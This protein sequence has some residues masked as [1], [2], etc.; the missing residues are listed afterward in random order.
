MNTILVGLNREWLL[1]EQVAQLFQLA[2]EARVLFTQDRAEM[3][4]VLDT[5]QIAVAGVPRDLVV[6]APNLRWLQQWG[7]GADWLLRCPRAV[8]QDWVLTNVSGIHA[9][10]I[11][12]HILA[13]LLAFARRLPESLRAQGRREWLTH[14]QSEV[15]ELA[16]STALVVGLGPIGQRTARLATAM[17]M[18]VLGV[19]R[20]TSLGVPGVEKI[21]SLD[22]IDELLPEADFVIV[23]VPLTAETK[24]FLSLREFQRMKPTAYLINIGR[25]GTINEQDL[26]TALREGRIAGAGLDVFETEP[27]PEDSPLWGM[28]NVIIT[29]HYAGSNPYYSQR[30]ME[31]FLDNLQRFQAG[32]PLRNVVNKALGY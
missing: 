18:R 1:E 24:G 13:L 4:A 31:I 17:G 29:S 23:T 2:G 10:P 3:E 25:G 7:A 16:G 19:R 21:I 27:L 8:E 9:I 11:S 30:A 5:V 26:I 12:E 15:F 6:R 22:Q 14:V 28:E 20:D 32:K